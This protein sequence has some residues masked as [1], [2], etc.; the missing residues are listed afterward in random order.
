MK[1]HN[2]KRPNI[3]TQCLD[4][5]SIGPSHQFLLSPYGL[6][7]RVGASVTTFSDINMGSFSV[8][9]LTIT[10]WLLL[11]FLQSL[12]VLLTTNHFKLPC[13]KVRIEVL[14]GFL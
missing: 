8:E 14:L 12:K 2:P 5:L 11:V 10:V 4:F 6:E 13:I 7:L 3:S 9:P 1:T